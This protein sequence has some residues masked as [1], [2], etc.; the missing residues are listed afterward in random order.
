MTF[1]Y[2]RDDVSKFL[3]KY[4]ELG[5]LQNDPFEVLDQRGVGQLIQIA[6]ERGRS[7][8][9][10]L[11]VCTRPQ[12]QALVTSHKSQVASRKSL[13]VSRDGLRSG[14]QGADVITVRRARR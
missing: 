3:P 13:V 14:D 1:G 11:K 4:L 12:A 10:N 2:S 5:I 6:T 7:T 9:P 8:R